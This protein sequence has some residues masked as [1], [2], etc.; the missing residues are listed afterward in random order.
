MRRG[1]ACYAPTDDNM[2]YRTVGADPCV[3]PKRGE[4]ANT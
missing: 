2:Q 3:Y 4:W 1:V